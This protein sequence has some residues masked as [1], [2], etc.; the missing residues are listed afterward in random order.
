MPASQW[1]EISISSFS[2]I[3]LRH[4]SKYFICFTR[5]DLE[6]VK[7]RFWLLLSSITWIMI[8]SLKFIALKFNMKFSSTGVILS[9]R[10]GGGFSCFCF[11]LEGVDSSLISSEAAVVVFEGGG[12]S[13]FLTRS[14]F[15]PWSAGVILFDILL[16][17]LVFGL[18]WIV[19]LIGLSCTS[20]LF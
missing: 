20:V 12:V 10:G 16:T 14:D 5:S 6:K 7:S 4:L 2:D 13:V 11:K 18:S 15:N 17:L 3:F 19:S 8:L 1:I 9:R